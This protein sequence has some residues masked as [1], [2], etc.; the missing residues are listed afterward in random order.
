MISFSD[1]QLSQWLADFLWPMIRILALFTAAP[2]LSM[3]QVPA[4][5]RIL[6]ALMITLL[7]QPMLPA[8]P[9]VPV[10]SADALLLMVQQ[11][12]IGAAMGFLLQL[13]FQ[14]LIFGGQASAYSMGLGFAQ[15]MDPA[16]GVQVPIVSQYYQLLA[17]L[18]FLLGNGH[19]V[20]IQ[21]VVDSFS[22][23][24]VATDALGRAGL[25]ELVAWASNVFS[26]GVLMA[27][28]ILVSLLLVN[29]GLGVVGRAAP[30]LNIFA[31]GFPITLIFGLVL[32][33]ATL[34]QVMTI[35]SNVFNG[36]MTLALPMLSTR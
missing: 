35:F 3:R 15:M 26:A 5:F 18:V 11:V 21:L 32:M 14:A 19:L 2:V 9:V 28:P 16:N 17:I 36:A 27:M 10:F 20:L 13:V 23:M 6:L 24:P 31:V 1:A 4:R 34:P 12:G 8:A 22:V 25:Y 33:W 7:A 29:I 30:Q